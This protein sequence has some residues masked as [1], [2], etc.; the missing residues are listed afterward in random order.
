MLLIEHRVNTVAHLSR[1]PTNRGVEVDI[2]DYDGDLRLAHDPFVGG[3]RLEDFLAAYR[4]TLIILNVKSDGL[5]QPILELLKNYQVNDYF[6]LDVANPTF[7]NMVRNDIHKIATHFSEFEPIDFSLAFAGK[8]DWVWVDCF[9]Q[10][11]LEPES[12]ER[13]SEHFKLCVVS[14]ELQNHPREMIQSFRQQLKDMP[15]EAVCTDF[16]DDWDSDD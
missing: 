3:E 2:R 5:V 4:H 11:P 12:Y 1:V 14:P 10:L 16:C 9:T 15:I 7:V 8:V 13:L 6:F